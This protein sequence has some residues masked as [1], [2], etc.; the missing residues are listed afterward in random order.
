MSRLGIDY[1]KV[2]LGLA[3]G[4]VI[5]RE[6]TTISNNGAA[7]QRI[8]QIVMKERIEQIIIGRPKRSQ[9][10]AGTLE[11]EIMQFAQKL[12]EAL[13]AVQIFFVDEAF[14]STQAETDLISKGLSRKE[15]KLSIDQYAAQLL[16]DQYNSEHPV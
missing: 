7:V 16:L 12:K 2:H 14:T 11:S 10:E 1:G 4:S 5:A 3:I 9:G 8:V 15:I 13:P 6:F